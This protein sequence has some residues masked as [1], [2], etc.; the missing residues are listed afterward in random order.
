MPWYAPR[1]VSICV[2]EP[3]PGSATICF[4][5]ASR[6]TIRSATSDG[7]DDAISS[8]GGS[9]GSRSAGN[10]AAIARWFERKCEYRRATCHS[11]RAR[12]APCTPSRTLITYFVITGRDDWPK[13]DDVV[14]PS[15]L[16]VCVI[17]VAMREEEEDASGFDMPQFWERRGGCGGELRGR[18]DERGARRDGRQG[19][20][21]EHARRA[22]SQATNL[23]LPVLHLDGI[24]ALRR[25][26][27]PTAGLTPKILTP[28]ALP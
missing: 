28:R 17:S 15:T 2:H 24:A 5:Y 8:R 9:F 16:I 26:R 23:R 11:S 25:A 13:T 19:L 10:I 12:S 3:T 27:P 7:F 6:P 20:P 18:H 1:K 14:L 4:R 21:A 22:S